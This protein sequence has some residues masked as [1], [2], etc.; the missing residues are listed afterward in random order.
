[1]GVGL[2]LPGLL[3]AHPLV[4]HAD[5]K[6]TSVSSRS[7]V[8]PRDPTPSPAPCTHTVKS[9]DT[10]SRIAARYGVG[11]PAV[12]AAN[13]LARPDALRLG[14]RLTIP[15]CNGRRGERVAEAPAP[16]ILT[17]GILLAKVGPR[18]VPTQL[19]LG[20]PEM[21]GRAIDFVWPV[22]GPIASPFGRR[23]NGWHAG[24]DIKANMGSPIVAAAPGTVFFNGWERSYGRVVRIEHDNRFVTVYAHTL[25]NFVEAGDRVEAGTVIATVGRS[26]RSTAG[27]LHFEIRRQSTVYDPVHL[28]PE[29]GV[30][31][32]RA[33]E[34]SDMHAEE[35]EDE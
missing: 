6:S 15:G 28:L 29:R 12:V 31:L 7:P 2:L 27:H 20:V 23:R 9:G 8:P 13:R 3:L 10:V 26:G 14:Q 21:D 33:D 34:A 24:L 30:R 32:A 4:T 35:D 22:M 25:Q 18:R 11:R 19:Y 16:A 17:D 1:M 5:P